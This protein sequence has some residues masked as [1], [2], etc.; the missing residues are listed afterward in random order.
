MNTYKIMQHY[1]IFFLYR[2]ALHLSM[3]GFLKHFRDA[4]STEN[5]IKFD[6]QMN[7]EL[8]DNQ[9]IN[10]K[11]KSTPFDFA[12]IIVVSLFHLNSF[13]TSICIYI[14]I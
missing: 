10:K 3:C 13:V 9:G 6:T 7:D 5:Q 2:S 12:F 8:I 11:I 1:S 14:Y 4:I